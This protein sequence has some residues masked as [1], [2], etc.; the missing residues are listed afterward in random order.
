MTPEQRE[1]L[2]PC[3]FCGS[4]A[5]IDEQPPH[6]HSGPLAGFMPDYPGSFTVECMGAG[7]NTGQI[8][9]THAGAVAMWNR[10]AQVEVLTVPLSEDDVEEVSQS[11]ADRVNAL[12][13]NAELRAAAT[14]VVARWDSPMWKHETH[15][16]EL[17]D[18]LRKSLATN[19]TVATYQPSGNSSE[20]PDEKGEGP[21]VD[22][23]EI[24]R[25]SLSNSPEIEGI[26]PRG[27]KMVPVELT[28]DMLIAFAE[29]WYSKK[30]C[31]DDCEM[32][33]CYAAMLEAAPTIPAIPGT[34]TKKYFPSP[35]DFK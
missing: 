3:P 8:A 16:G 13:P 30:R 20:L 10:R 25:R 28:D 21:T 33:D 9:D 2:K 12:A 35:A 7:C 6:S 32:A 17:V 18:R 11:I 29:V 15:T 22:F 1:E 23:I 5:H 4:P 24:V 14:A 19:P 27:W 34:P 26:A 31:I